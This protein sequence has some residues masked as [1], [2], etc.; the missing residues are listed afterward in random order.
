VSLFKV[1]NILEIPGSQSKKGIAVSSIV[2]AIPCNRVSQLSS[3]QSTQRTCE[4]PGGMSEAIP[5]I[6]WLSRA[7]SAHPQ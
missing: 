3:H 2:F 5:I 7:M 4:T 6:L 1:F